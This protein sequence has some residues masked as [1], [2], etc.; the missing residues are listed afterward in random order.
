MNLGK[1]DSMML[2]MIGTR[3]PNWPVKKRMSIFIHKKLVKHVVLTILFI[4]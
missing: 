3:C 1:M 2:M 4:S